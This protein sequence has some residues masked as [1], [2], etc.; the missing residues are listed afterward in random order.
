VVPY[1]EHCFGAWY[2]R[3]GLYGLAGALADRISERGGRIRLG[4]RA[5]RLRVSGGRVEA[6]ELAGGGA[7][8]ADVVVSNA[9]A[10]LL[11]GQL[12][13]QPP[14]RI[15][16]ADSL[17]G[18][19]LMLGVRGRT[20]ALAHHTVLFGA[21]D[22]DAEFDAIFGRPGR[23]ITDPVLYVNAPD[24]PAVRPDGHEAWYILVNAPRHGTDG[25]RGELDW[26]AP[27]IA[28]GYADRILSLLAAR[29]L[30]VR[31]RVVF[32][33]IRTPA[34]L[35]RETLA[36]GG[37][38]Y[39]SVQHGALATLRRPRNRSATRGLFLVGGSTHPGGG[40]PLVT[41]SARIVASAVGPA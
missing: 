8:P 41:L 15:P 31:E 17:S 26:T 25:R 30:P 29:G 24:D 5:E 22:Y 7:L 33:E 14:R 37:A 3:G 39:G 21:E 16:P 40:L 27:G 10:S 18:F 2:V 4:T 13:E 32:S 35:E 12:H 34:D 1:L 23:P 20:P 11:Y 19:V 6:V 28:E 36:P 9:D 38:I